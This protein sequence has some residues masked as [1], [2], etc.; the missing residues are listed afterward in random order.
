MPATRGKVGMDHE[1]YKWSPIIKR[2]K[3]KWPKGARVALAV[4]VNVEHM[5]WNP[6]EGHYQVAGLYSRG[7]PDIRVTSH[8][9]YGKRV[10]VYRLLDVLEKHGM[11]ATVSMDA[12]TA[13]NYPYLVKHC[14]ERGCEIIAHGVSLSRMITSQM[15]EAEERKEIKTA[16]DAV[17][18]ATG[19]APLGW[20][21]PEYGE[22][23]RT[24]Q[25]L[26]EAGIRYVCD[27]V[28][29]EQ[30][31]PM[32]TKKGELYALPMNLDLDDDFALRERKYPMDEY[33]KLLV[34]AFDTMHKDG[35][36][37]GR[38]LTLNLH[39]WTSGQPFRTYYLDQALG[40]MMGKGSVWAATGREIIEW[41]RKEA[42]KGKG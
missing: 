28:N 29:D 36:E 24:P 4:V 20:F 13:Q 27:W 11:P 6:P 7:L 30:P 2:P 9:E 33:S 1:H 18:K 16:I 5:E 10:G 22:S 25:L 17:E 32:T 8:R 12:L 39:A 23:H 34:D 19:K 15:S 3:L 40:R 41:Y 26:A 42:G 31:Y 38:V 21:G 37:T 35:S 14:I